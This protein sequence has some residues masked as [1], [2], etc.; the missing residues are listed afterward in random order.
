[1]D[2]TYKEKHWALE[3]LM[4]PDGYRILTSCPACMCESTMC[5]VDKLLAPTP[6]I[7]ANIA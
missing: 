2:A 1:M 5:C 3:A 4:F 7:K 6:S